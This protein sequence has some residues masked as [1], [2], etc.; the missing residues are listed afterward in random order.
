MSADWEERAHQI[1][2]D[3]VDLG[4]EE[5]AVF[6]RNACAGD[7][8]LHEEV[9]S[10][11]TSY[12]GDPFFLEPVSP[13]QPTDEHGIGELG[14]Y[15]LLR[16]LGRGGQGSVYLAR[17]RN[18]GREV[19]LKVLSVAF[20]AAPDALQRFRREA[21]AASRIDHPGICTVYEAG[22]IRGMPRNSGFRERCKVRSYFS[23]KRDAGRVTAQ[24][25]LAYTPCAAANF[26]MPI[27]R[28]SSRPPSS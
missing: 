18:L 10:L 28:R 22:E 5:R 2:N 4:L 19:A 3:A 26:W 6:L 21:E 9:Q 27:P 23:R 20:A 16:E 11:L 14:H 12:D 24:K 7:E 8:A 25:G 1:F 17:D 15:L 13:A